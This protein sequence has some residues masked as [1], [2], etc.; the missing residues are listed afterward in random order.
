[1]GSGRLYRVVS[2]SDSKWQRSVQLT[3]AVQ[4][5]LPA[6]REG[7]QRHPISRPER[8][9]TSKLDGLIR[10]DAI[11]ASDLRMQQGRPRMAQGDSCP[12]SLPACAKGYL[13]V[14]GERCSEA[15][16]SGE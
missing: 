10:S 3:E 8:G 13:S 5:K 1:M 7:E 2:R 6:Q 16:E 4:R 12:T 11:Q 15:E 9:R 14:R